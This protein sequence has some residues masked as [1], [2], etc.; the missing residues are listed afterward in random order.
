LDIIDEA[1]LL[2]D[3]VSTNP[4]ASNLLIRSCPLADPRSSPEK[5]RS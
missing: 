5:D 2:Q 1:L 4:T 3:P